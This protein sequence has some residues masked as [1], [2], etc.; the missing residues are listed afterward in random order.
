MSSRAIL[1]GLCRLV[2]D[3]YSMC[4]D[5]MVSGDSSL[6]PTNTQTVDNFDLLIESP[7]DWLVLDTENP[8]SSGLYALSSLSS[9][10]TRMP[11]F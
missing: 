6:G 5:V 2:L 1:G 4:H 9:E 11:S 7:L 10:L 3:R 8:Q